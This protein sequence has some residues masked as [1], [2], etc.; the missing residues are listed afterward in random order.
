MVRVTI[1]VVGKNQTEYVGEIHIINILGHPEFPYKSNYLIKEFDDNGDEQRRTE[2]EG[3][4][5]SLGAMP[6]VIDAFKRLK[7]SEPVIPTEAWAN[8]KAKEV[9][10]K[11]ARDEKS[12]LEPLVAAALRE[13]I[14]QGALLQQRT[15]DPASVDQKP[16]EYSDETLT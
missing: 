8:A 11:W 9:A 2:L 3:F 12:L 6:L 4:D 15:A 5:R 1:E 7:G 13:A 14:I 10:I 16:D